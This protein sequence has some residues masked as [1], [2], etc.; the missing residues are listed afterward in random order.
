MKETH[1]KERRAFVKSTHAFK[2]RQ[3]NSEVH[4]ESGSNW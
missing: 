4:S 3:F 2:C 1:R